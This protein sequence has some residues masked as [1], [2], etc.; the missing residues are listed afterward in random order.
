[1][2]SAEPTITTGMIARPSRPSVRFTALPNDTIVNAA[3]TGKNQP[4]SRY[5]RE[6]NGRYRCGPFCDMMIVA[7]TPAMMNSSNNRVRPLIPAVLALRTL[8]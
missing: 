7:A 5:M 6:V 2:P 1:M 8:S 3:N 4:K